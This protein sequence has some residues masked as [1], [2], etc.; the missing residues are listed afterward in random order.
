MSPAGRIQSIEFIGRRP[1]CGNKLA[2]SRPFGGIENEATVAKVDQP[3]VRTCCR[4]GKGG[5]SQV[6]FHLRRAS[7]TNPL[8]AGDRPHFSQNDED[9][10]L[11][12][13]VRALLAGGLAPDIFILEYNPKFPPSVEFEMPYDADHRWRGDDYFGVSLLKWTKILSPVGYTLIACNENGVNA[14]FVK[15]RHMGRFADISTKIE[16]LYRC[17]FN[18]NPTSPRTVQHLVTARD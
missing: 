3:P 6:N 16:E 12:E 7:I 13:N 5:I 10:I 1:N 8:L 9:G 11:L 4:A 18:Q 14:F 17:G 15:T 2:S